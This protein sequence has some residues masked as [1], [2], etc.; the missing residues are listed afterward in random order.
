M[1]LIILALAILL[2][3]NKNSPT[4]WIFAW[5]GTVMH[6]T[7]HW[8]VGKVMGAEPVRFSVL[9]EKD[10]NLIGS[11]SFANITWFNCVPVTMAPLL[12]VPLAYFLYGYI[13]HI[14]I[15]SIKGIAMIWTFAAILAS[16]WPSSVDFKLSARHPEGWLFWGG[17]AVLYFGNKYYHFFG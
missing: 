13:P 15:W 7:L 1:S 4:F 16:S 3:L 10:S 9:P 12:G 14:E 5:P 6:E 8:T 17:L 2:F 11:V